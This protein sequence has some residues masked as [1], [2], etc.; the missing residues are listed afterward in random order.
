MSQ[1]RCRPTRSRGLS[2]GRGAPPPHG[3]SLPSIAV[4]PQGKKGAVAPARPLGG[5]IATRPLWFVN[6]RPAAGGPSAER[7][8]DGLVRG[9]PEPSRP[10]GVQK[11][12]LGVVG[13]R[14]RPPGRPPC[15][16]PTLP[17][18]PLLRISAV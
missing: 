2:S 7:R 15:G 6:E 13:P 4:P 17:E 1:P 10:S 3:T 14:P 11:F 8:A 18:R 12:P 5:W 9:P 16:F